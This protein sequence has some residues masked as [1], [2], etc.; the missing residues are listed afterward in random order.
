MP[1]E[2]PRKLRVNTQLQAE[3]AQLIRT[4]LA[5]PR[6]VGVTVTGVDVTADM[7]QARVTVSLLGSDELLKEAVAGL[8]HAAGKLR[9]GLGERMLLRTVPALRF[10]PDM[11]LREGDRVSGLIRNAVAEDQKHA[12]E[13]DDE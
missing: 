2:F 8:N 12:E 6:V 11:A 10:V 7:R 9:H 4:Q 1:R 13:R 5:D 3:L